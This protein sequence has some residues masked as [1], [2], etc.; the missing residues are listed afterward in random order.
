MLF[1]SIAE[2]DWEAKLTVFEMT[3]EGSVEPTREER[4]QV[5]SVRKGEIAEVLV[6]Y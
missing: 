5:V 1:R 3:G 4:K 6:Q 2:G